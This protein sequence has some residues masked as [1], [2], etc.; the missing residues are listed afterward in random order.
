MKNHHEET[1]GQI[2]RFLNSFVCIVC[3]VFKRLV[4][5]ADNGFVAEDEMFDAVHR[6]M[7][8]IFFRKLEMIRDFVF[9][10]T[11][12]PRERAFPYFVL[13][14]RLHPKH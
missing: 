7:R 5:K 2:P 1:P 3:G 14:D 9:G 13:S 8:M 10:E 6:T 4:R 11:Y 12:F